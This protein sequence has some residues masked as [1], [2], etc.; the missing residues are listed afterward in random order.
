MPD[1]FDPI[2]ETEIM[3]RFENKMKLILDA[4]LLL[5]GGK[6]LD[7]FQLLKYS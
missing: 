4:F 2:E 1:D 3:E 7:F 5:M 6:E